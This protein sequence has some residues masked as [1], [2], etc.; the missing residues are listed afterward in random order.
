MY[1]L[2]LRAPET[3]RPLCMECLFTAAICKTV[4]EGENHVDDL[5]DLDFTNISDMSDGLIKDKPRVQQRSISRRL[6]YVLWNA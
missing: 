5:H 2:C 1:Q 4:Q 3:A 6:L